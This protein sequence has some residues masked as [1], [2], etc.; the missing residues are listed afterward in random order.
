[1]EVSGHIH[2]LA[3]LTPGKESLVLFELEAGWVPRAGVDDVYL[4]VS[5]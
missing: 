5:F 1:M 3:P 2:P 4:E